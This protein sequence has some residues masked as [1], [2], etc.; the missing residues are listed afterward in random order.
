MNFFL[1]FFFTLIIYRARL[2]MY[3]LLVA[4]LLYHISLSSTLHLN[5]RVQS[6]L[7]VLSTSLSISPTFFLLSKQLKHVCHFTKTSCIPSLEVLTRRSPF[8]EA[9]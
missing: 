2:S 4:A 8:L 3:Y 9:R 7:S 6:F 5:L 1:R